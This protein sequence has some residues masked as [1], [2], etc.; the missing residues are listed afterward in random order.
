VWFHGGVQ[1]TRS[2]NSIFYDSGRPG[3][4]LA[5]I[6]SVMAGDASSLRSAAHVIAQRKFAQGRAPMFLYSFTR[7]SPVRNGKLHSMHG[8]EL[9]FVSITRTRS[10]S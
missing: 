2:G 3:E 5:D 10:H 8:M 1:R 9:P 4:S 7:G 6:A